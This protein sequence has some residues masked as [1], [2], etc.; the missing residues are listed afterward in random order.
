VQLGTP[1][2]EL[3]FAD[4]RVDAVVEDAAHGVSGRRERATHLQDVVPE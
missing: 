3:N 4:T 1:V 2:E